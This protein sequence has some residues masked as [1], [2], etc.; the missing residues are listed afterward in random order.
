MRPAME[1]KFERI[2][3][4]SAPPACER[5]SIALLPAGGDLWEDF[6]DSIGI[7]LERFCTEGPGGWMLGYMD[8]L[9]RAG[10]RTVLIFFSGRVDRPTRHRQADTGNLIT[11]LPAPSRYRT[12]RRKLPTYRDAPS[13]SFR[14][15]LAD[16]LEPVA[17]YLSTPLSA[18]VRE[19]RRERCQAILCQEYE[20]FR[21]DQCVALGRLLRVPV[22]A[23]FQGSDS[24]HNRWSR[25]VKGPVIGRSAGLLIAA[26]TEI[27]RVHRVYGKHAPQVRQIFNPV[28]LDDWG[29]AEREEARAALGFGPNTRVAVWHGRIAFYSKGLDVMLKA[30]AQIC[31][32][33][34]HRDLRLMLLGTGADAEEFARHIAASTAP[35]IHWVN[36]YITDRASIRRFLAAGDVFAFPSRLEGFAVA[37]IEAMACGLPVVA[38]DASGVSDIFRQGEA[39]GGIVVPRGDAGAFASALGRI[40]DDPEHGAELGR[41]ARRRVEQA[42]SLDTVGQQL[43]AAMLGAGPSA[44]S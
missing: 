40:L 13:G 6:L 28:D 19:L 41:R 14:A 4:N 23:S 34:A 10:V 30:W 12:L 17:P 7:S 44:T 32:E 21:F 2:D 26:R 15:R 31:R 27:E 33:R 11:V 9:S 37:P 22:F 43:R 5:P 38:A 8:A 36:E 16:W 1:A 18:L 35:G 42:F 20:Y 39:A 25:A 24:E 3:G 29:G